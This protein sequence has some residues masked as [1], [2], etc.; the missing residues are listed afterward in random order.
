MDEKL[1]EPPARI[2]ENYVPN[3]GG[4]KSI[5]EKIKTLTGAPN[6]R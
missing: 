5:V 4:N 6:G 2:P 3:Q 1:K